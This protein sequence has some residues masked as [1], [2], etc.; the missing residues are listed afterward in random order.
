MV[1]NQ[2]NH[3]LFQEELTLAGT[4]VLKE[5][6]LILVIQL[7]VAVLV[8]MVPLVAVLEQAEQDFNILSLMHL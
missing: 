5:E 2:V 7:E 1:L 6:H 4:V 3:N 8:A